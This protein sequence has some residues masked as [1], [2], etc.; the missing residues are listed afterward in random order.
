MTTA[1]LV[2]VVYF[3]ILLPIIKLQNVENSMVLLVDNNPQNRQQW[4]V[5]DSEQPLTWIYPLEPFYQPEG[6]CKIVVN[7]IITKFIN[8]NKVCEELTIRLEKFSFDN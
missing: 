1:D 2:T 5:T 8:L 4:C 3:V 7:Y 6:M